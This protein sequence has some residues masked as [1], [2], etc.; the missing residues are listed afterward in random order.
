MQ[1]RVGDFPVETVPDGDRDV[2]GSGDARGEL[3]HLKVQVAVVVNR[4]NLALK[5][6]FE[7]L[8]VHNEA[9]DGIDLAGD[10]DLQ[11]V[12]MAVPVAIGA[13]A[14]D[15][16][17]LLRRPGVV[18]VVVGGGKFGFAGQQDHGYPSMSSGTYKS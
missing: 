12:V 8:E 1:L 16:C 2:L 3:R 9:G 15:A 11:G 13:L 4:N 14:E 6:V 10:G 5:D 18:P 7:L 17:V